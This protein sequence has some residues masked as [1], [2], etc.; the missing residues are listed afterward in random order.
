MLSLDFINFINVGDVR[1]IEPCGRSCF[2]LEPTQS[3]FVVG[4]L[5]GKYLQG[6]FAM[7]PRIVRQIN[8]THGARAE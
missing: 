2:L 5:G 3:V 4:K 8:L 6:Y 1:M 7:Q